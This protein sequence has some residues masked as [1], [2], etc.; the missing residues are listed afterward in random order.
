MKPSDYFIDRQIEYDG[1]QLFVQ[2][3]IL[4]G[5]LLGECN[6]TDP[7]SWFEALQDWYDWSSV[8]FQVKETKKHISNLAEIENLL[9]SV[10]KKDIAGKQQYYTELEKIERKEAAYK[11]I[12]K[13]FQDIH[14]ELYMK[15]VYMPIKKP[16]NAARAIANY[17]EVFESE[18]Q[19]EVVE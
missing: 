18:Q 10:A 3:L 17:T 14:R 19:D 6:Y 8:F 2:E 12:R 1:R 11:L 4:R 7:K 15:G 9:F 16:K 13:F 5:H